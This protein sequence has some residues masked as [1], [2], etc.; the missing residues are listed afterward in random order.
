MKNKFTS[1]SGQTLVTLL[2]FMVI[3]LT[4]TAASAIIII[5]N[6]TTTG[7]LEQ[8]TT[9]YYS[10]ESGIE[11]ALLRFLR[12][13]SFTGESFTVDNNTVTSVV[14]P[15]GGETY[16]FIA[17]SSAN[18]TVRTIQVTSVY[19]NHVMQIQSWKEIK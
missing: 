18:Q 3:S 16:I 5:V 17:T 19:N 4:V 14:T 2:F 10:A 15:G 1:N 7:T 13:P 9:T 8:G 12:N 11:N 6:A